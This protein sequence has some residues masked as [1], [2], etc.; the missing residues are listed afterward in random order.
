[1]IQTIAGASARNMDE[2]VAAMQRN[3]KT[4]LGLVED[5]S[6]QPA[7]LVFPRFEEV[8]T[9][10]NED[11]RKALRDNLL[12]VLRG[13]KGHHIIVAIRS[14][15]VPHVAQLGTL[16]TQFHKGEVFVPP[17]DA[18]EL[19]QVV[20]QPAERVGL[21]FEDGLVDRL[22]FEVL[23]DP[24]A[25]PLLQFTLLRL[26]DRRERNHITWKAFREV[27]GCRGAFEKAANEM[28][29]KLNRSEQD[30][31]KAIL[32]R[33]VRPGA[34]REIICSSVQRVS[35]YKDGESHEQIDRVID[36]LVSAGLARLAGAHDADQRIRI[37]NEAL[38]TKW[39]RFMEWLEDNR[40]QMRQRQRLT[41]AAVQWQEKGEDPEALW[42]GLLLEEARNYDDLNDLEAE[43]VSASVRAKER[44]DRLRRRL[45]A[46]AV[47]VLVAGIS[48]LVLTLWL[49]YL[50]LSLKDRQ[51]TVDH[52]MLLL[53]TGNPAAGTVEFARPI[54]PPK[55][56]YVSLFP[57]FDRL[58]IRGLTQLLHWIPGLQLPDQIKTNVYRRRLEIGLRQLPRL[59]N[60]LP[61]DRELAYA[62]MSND[63]R[64]IAT[65]TS[66][67]EES[68]VACDACWGTGPQTVWLW[69]ITGTEPPAEPRSLQ[70][71]LFPRSARSVRISPDGKF[72]VSTHGD[73]T[74]SIGE[75]Q[76]W[77]ITGNEPHCIRQLACDGFVTLAIWSRD[78]SNRV[79][80]AQQINKTSQGK[81][82]VWDW[83]NEATP[84]KSRDLEKISLLEWSPRGDR[85]VIAL[86]KK[87]EAQIWDLTSDQTRSFKSETVIRDVVF[88]SDSELVLT[89]AGASGPEAGASET[90]T[91]TAQ[92]WKAK[93]GERSGPSLS[94][95][96][97]VRSAQFS[98]DNKLVV[99][100]SM[101]G[102]AKVW[103]VSTGR[104]ML[105]L[106]HDAGV[107]SATF[108]P[109]GR[110]IATG[111][112][113]RMARVWELLSGKL[114][115][116]P[117]NHG[118]T[119]G[120][121]AFSLDGRKLI[122]TSK[123]T[124]RVWAF[125]TGIK[126]PP[127]LSTDGLI[128]F[129]AF[130]HDGSRL[131]T[132]SEAEPGKI[133]TAQVWKAL[134][135]VWVSVS[136]Y[137]QSHLPLTRAAISDDGSRVW[138]GSGDADKHV[139]Q[140]VVI[141]ATN[142]T[143]LWDKPITLEGD[144]TF[145]AFGHGDGR[146]VTLTQ[147]SKEGTTIA[148]VWNANTG[149]PLT[150]PLRHDLPVY[151]ATLSPDNSRLLT[152]GGE[153]NPPSGP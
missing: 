150:N 138:L 46:A 91:G 15:F 120:K 121:I 52:G 128:S 74:K 44:K 43:F 136:N 110:Y 85:I 133:W 141:D 100:A 71:N 18:G 34:G 139:Y 31:A 57:G 56:V 6:N 147:D 50:N 81:V 102:T 62:E 2:L 148:Q 39:P 32:L 123:E 125:A 21:K 90:E 61:H 73:A 64:H 114:A 122:T 69:T 111:A 106:S 145:I 126:A 33:I 112:R 22:I 51:A 66:A 95:K 20:E 109:D 68:S 130:N 4:L 28:F 143:A 5:D 11:E 115:L 35:L 99:T 149:E 117:I 60:L 116:P 9:L 40:T 132:L 108:S 83:Q 153:R 58:D 119:V 59:L 140:A 14:E 84:G 48:L 63:G 29:S 93:T 87:G 144:P 70:S 25:L 127:A 96:G 103:S 107:F 30:L 75:V 94:H 86:Q 16:E 146:V 65:L 23:G 80:F 1:V 98:P 27:G 53:A 135:G 97:A 72:V 118:G 129:A 26:W 89:A 24:A 82:M 19:R 104:E 49:A 151:F 17:F 45:K 36:A 13:P 77:D 76:I 134:T 55:H 124:A 10:A 137:Q 12:E 105:T 3:S 78:G 54:A 79:A 47:F 92:I 42:G 131:V 8:F 38:I 142:G 41:I 67:A 113:D 152:A 37:V 7:L 88:S 101:D